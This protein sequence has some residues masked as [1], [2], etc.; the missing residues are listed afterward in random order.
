MNLTVAA[1]DRFYGASES[2]ETYDTVRMQW[3]SQND[4]DVTSHTGR[5]AFSYVRIT[6]IPIQRGVSFLSL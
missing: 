2:L 4:A 5:P 1:V 6:L 3:H